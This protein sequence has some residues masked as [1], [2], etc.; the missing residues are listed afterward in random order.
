MNNGEKK[1]N[2]REY[3]MEYRKKKKKQFNV[4]L[5]IPVYEELDQLLK[6]KNLTRTQF[7]RNAMENLKKE[8][9]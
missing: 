1:F 4:D 2:K 8:G 7:V 5:N 6:S 9:E 3:D